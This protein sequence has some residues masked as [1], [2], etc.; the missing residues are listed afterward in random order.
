MPLESGPR[1]V[2]SGAM[3]QFVRDSKGDATERCGGEVFSIYM[4]WDGS[5]MSIEAMLRHQF[6]VRHRYHGTETGLIQIS[7]QHIASLWLII[8]V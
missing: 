6:R 4:D 1:N 8:L 5:P 7:L 2:Y 3:L